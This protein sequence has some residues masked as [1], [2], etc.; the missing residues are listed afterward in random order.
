[1]K[2]QWL[3]CIRTIKRQMAIFLSLPPISPVSIFSAP[4]IN[5]RK[6]QNPVWGLE[7]ILFVTSIDGWKIKSNNFS[8]EIT[9]LKKNRIYSY[10]VLSWSGWSG[11]YIAYHFLLFISLSY[12][13]QQKLFTVFYIVLMAYLSQDFK[14]SHVWYWSIIRINFKIWNIFL[15]NCHI[16]FK[17]FFFFFIFV[18]SD[19]I[20][21]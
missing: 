14:H 17:C 20:K 5:K 19:W 13:R 4:I 10:L 7:R 1:M 16:L 3:H 8:M 18:F 11:Y 21:W 6:C 15:S 2:L 12:F 9:I